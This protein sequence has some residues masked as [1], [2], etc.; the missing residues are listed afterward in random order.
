MSECPVPWPEPYNFR[1][2]GQKQPQVVATASL[3]RLYLENRPYIVSGYCQNRVGNAC[4]ESL[5]PV[6][7]PDA[8]QQEAIG[9]VSSMVEKY[10]IMKA[11]FRKR[12]TFGEFYSVSYPSVFCISIAYPSGVDQVFIPF[13][14]NIF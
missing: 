13:S 6:G 9:N 1:R 3:K 8:V 2:R 14:K 4:S 11:T 12:L 7:L 5:Q 10:T